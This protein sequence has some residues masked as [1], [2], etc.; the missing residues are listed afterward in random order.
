MK[1]FISWSGSTSR[2]VALALSEWI[3]KVIQGVTPYVSAKD[4]DKGSNWTVELAKE[5]EDTEFGI[6]CLAPDNL[7]S[8]WLH[9]EAGAITKSVDSRV[10]PVLF[11]VE[12]TSVGHPLAQLQLTSIDAEDF[13]LLMMS[14]SKVAGNHLTPERIKE[15]VK[16][17]WPS[18][19]ESLATIESPKPPKE[20]QARVA[21]EPDKPEANS[22][23]LMSEM[24][25]LVRR[26]DRRLR[27]L[28]T[29]TR[30][31]EESL[32]EEPQLRDHRYK[33]L[34]RDLVA[35]DIYRYNMRKRPDR[36]V[37]EIP[38]PVDDEK[39]GV[40]G[41]IVS[42]EAVRQGKDVW[43]TFNGKTLISDSN[44]QVSEVPF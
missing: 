3:P 2:A 35:A 13:E 26:M 28:E 25:S 6:I 38:S 18:L 29:P 41:E 27:M 30:N 23:E 39:A 1:V 15:S 33:E 21:Q 7:S 34:S 43:V 24:L 20:G 12:K 44:G 31:R 8:P 5:L 9:Y 4:L 11:Q 14:I 37:I 17:W 42:R 16:V 40:L 22:D 10:A 32:H 19:E 36:L